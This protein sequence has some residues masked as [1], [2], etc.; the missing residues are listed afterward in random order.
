MNEH[1]TKRIVH[2]RMQNL[3][4]YK[5]IQRQSQVPPSLAY[6]PNYDFNKKR[7]ANVFIS[8]TKF[9]REAMPKLKSCSQPT[10]RERL[11]EEQQ[12][13]KKRGNQAEQALNRLMK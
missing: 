6:M 4:S 7:P 2:K 1:L 13:A 11:E 8:K 10:I 5:S 9:S 3:V 12:E